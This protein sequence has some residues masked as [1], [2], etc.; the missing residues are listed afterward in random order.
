M[1]LESLKPP[2]PLLE[3]FSTLTGMSSE[4]L[5][6]IPIDPSDSNRSSKPRGR[7]KGV[8]NRVKIKVQSPGSASVGAGAVLK[9][10]RNSKINGKGRSRSES[11]PMFGNGKRPNSS[12]SLVDETLS[13]VLD[14][15]AYDKNI[16][17]QMVFKEGINDRDLANKNVVKDNSYCFSNGN[18]G[19][20]IK[21]PSKS[22]MAVSNDHSNCVKNKGGVVEGSVDPC[23]V[24]NGASKLGMADVE[25]I[26]G[27]GTRKASKD[28]LVNG[29]G[30]SD[31]VFGKLDF[32]RVLVEVV[33]DDELPNTLEIAYPQLGNRPARVGK[34]EARSR[35]EEEIAA[36][37]L[38]AAG[39]GEVLVTKMSNTENND[40]DGFATVGRKNR[41]VVNNGNANQSNDMSRNSSGN[42]FH[43]KGAQRFARQNFGSMKQSFSGQGPNQ[44]SKSNGVNQQRSQFK[45]KGVL[46]DQKVVQQNKNVK[47]V[48]KGSLVQ[49]LE[50]YSKYNS[51]FWPKVLVKGSESNSSVGALVENVPVTNS[52]DVLG[53]CDMVDKE[54][55]L[56]ASESA[57]Y[58]DVIWPKLRMEVENVMKSGLNN[59]PNQKQVTDLLS[60]GSY[61]FC[62]LLETKVKKKN[63]IKIFSKVLGRWS[64]MSNAYECAGGT[65]I[66][67]GWDPN[68]VRVMLHSQ[69]AQLMNVFV[70]S[71]NGH[72][73]F[74]CSFVYAHIKVNGRKSLWKDLCIHIATRSPKVRKDL[75]GDNSDKTKKGRYSSTSAKEGEKRKRGRPKKFKASTSVDG[76]HVISMVDDDKELKLGTSNGPIDVTEYKVH[77]I[78]GVP[79]GELSID[80]LEE[81]KPDDPFIKEWFQQFP[82]GKKDIRPNDITDVIVASDDHGKLFRMNFLMLFANTMGICDTQGAC[83]MNILKRIND[84]IIEKVESINWCKF[85]IDSLVQSLQRWK[86][87]KSTHFTGPQTF[88]T[89][90]YLDSTRCDAFPVQR[91]RPAIR[92]WKTIL[93]KYREK[94]EIESGGFGLLPKEDDVYINSL[95][96]KNFVEKIQMSFNNI[97][98]EMASISSSLKK[99]EFKKGISSNAFMEEDRGCDESQAEANSTENITAESQYRMQAEST[100][101]VDKPIEDKSQHSEKEHEPPVEIE[102]P[103]KEH[104]VSDILN[105]EKEGSI[106]DQSERS[107]QDISTDDGKTEV[108]EVTETNDSTNECDTDDSPMVEEQEIPAKSPMEESD[109]TASKT[110][111]GNS[112]MEGQAVEKSIEEKQVVADPS[113]TKAEDSTMEDQVAGKQKEPKIDAESSFKEDEPKAPTET[114]A[115][116]SN[117]PEKV[118]INKEV[119]DSVIHEEKTNEEDKNEGRPPTQDSAETVIQDSAQTV[120]QGNPFLKVIH[121]TLLKTTLMR[122]SYNRS[123]KALMKVLRMMKSILSHWKPLTWEPI[124]KSARGLPILY[125]FDMETITPN[126]EI[127][128]NVIDIWSEILNVMELYKEDMTLP[129]R[130]FFKISFINPLYFIENHTDEEKLQSFTKSIDESFTDDEKHLKSLETFDML[131]FPICREYHLY[132]ICADFKN[133]SFRVIDNSSNGTDFEE[134]YK[135]VPE[136]IKKVLVAYLD[137]VEHPKTERIRNTKQIRMQ[138]KWRTK[139]NHVDCGVFLM[140]HMESYHGFKNWDCGFHLESPKQKRELDLLRSKYATKILLSEL[141]LI[142]N[143]FLKLVQVF[144]KKSE[145]ERRKMIEYA[146]AH[147]NEHSRETR[148]NK[149]IR[150]K[151]SQASSQSSID[152]TASPASN[153]ASPASNKRGRPK[154]SQTNSQSNIDS[155]ASPASNPASP[156]SKKRGR[157]KKS[158]HDIAS[159]ASTASPSTDVKGKDKLIYLHSTHC[160]TDSMPH[161]TPAIEYWGSDDISDRDNFEFENGGF[162]IQDLY[163]KDNDDDDSFENKLKMDKLSQNVDLLKRILSDIN[164]EIKICSCKILD[165]LRL[166]EIKSKFNNCIRNEYLSGQDKEESENDEIM[167]FERESKDLNE[168]KGEDE[169]T[170]FEKKNMMLIWDLKKK[171][172]NENK[173]SDDD[174]DGFKNVSKEEINENEKKNESQS[175]EEV[176]ETGHGSQSKDEEIKLL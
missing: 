30:G 121:Y 33:A 12:N 124:F 166:K 115:D 153:P 80:C 65:N 4:D 163:K 89:L 87:K 49:K 82:S 14:R 93:M 62:G 73:K 174:A 85:I 55:A 8:K 48:P 94:I 144:E 161:K 53:D 127:S 26:E 104:H 43:N 75:A 170:G 86:N 34:L 101:E 88:M 133:G 59:D 35:T 64:W 50:L 92:G 132:L 162:G 23:S 117:M 36:K 51:D 57:E 79:N 10:L 47:F 9:R 29:S 56:D 110:M 60:D 2:D 6:H 63:L 120:I 108:T 39:K 176:F 167:G 7:P 98:L 3:E 69:T 68:A 13:K 128:T 151:K 140:L 118:A 40:N 18:D 111:M 146:I 96:S 91:Q 150:P 25:H 20:F 72:H 149:R 67:V 17:K 81:R 16:S 122:R 19:S 99:E 131:F 31:F 84:D 41:P 109:A 141:N 46:G 45:Q 114:R 28:G 71:I 78:M 52:F 148:S 158:Q 136:E 58:E 44:Q 137:Q 77:E 147:R 126:L 156:A 157:P 83:S 145:N 95:Q 66:I 103:T 138:M 106:S 143:K 160:V 125:H 113:E 24:S 5:K 155:T 112:N 123:R 38:K 97:N 134:R 21:N 54:N 142:K 139:N 22:S 37:E 168:E 154:K 130:Y 100:N 129:S 152:S 70:E 135:G 1:P 171:N 42:F 105:Q 159:N 173:N 76:N 90:L 11:S 74:F 27:E 61:S 164:T 116:E 15:M 32:A 172:E 175:T 102:E 107:K 169:E 165:N 119:L